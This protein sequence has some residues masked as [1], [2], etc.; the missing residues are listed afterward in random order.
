MKFPCGLN[1]Y[2]CIFVLLTSSKFNLCITF[3]N[4]FERFE[5]EFSQIYPSK[6]VKVS[7]HRPTNETPFKWRFTG[8]PIVAR[9]CMLAGMLWF[10]N[11]KR[12]DAISLVCTL[13][14]EFFSKLCLCI[15]SKS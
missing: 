14:C 12:T 11:G 6:H 8:G 9:Y 7:H 5:Y 10:L 3:I 2:I 15:L 1:N 13:I 4:M